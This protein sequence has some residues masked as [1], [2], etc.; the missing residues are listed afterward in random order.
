M[1]HDLG[2]NMTSSMAL[3]KIFTAARPLVEEWLDI[4]EQMAAIRDTAT[5]QG[6]DWS[7]IKALLKAQVQ[8]E[9]DGRGD[10][11]RVNKIIEKAEFASAYADMLGLTNMNEFIISPGA[12]LP[13][14][15]EGEVAGE[16]ASPDVPHDP[17]TGE[18]AEPPR[19]G[20]PPDVDDEEGGAVIAAVPPS[21]RIADVQNMVREFNEWTP[22]PDITLPDFLRRK[23][24]EATA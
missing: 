22:P 19:E 2:Q 21:D 11:K 10:G 23:R 15:A 3:K 24:A 18:I 6:L 4:A 9:R 13:V 14:A 8:D 16:P 12:A 20:S 17:I 7:Q 5:A 1:P